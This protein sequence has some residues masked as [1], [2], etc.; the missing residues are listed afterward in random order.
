MD[1]SIN[2][3]ISQDKRQ[4]RLSRLLSPTAVI[5]RLRKVSGLGPLTNR[6]IVILVLLIY[7]LTGPVG[8][9]TDIVSASLAYALLVF[10]VLITA[11]VWIQ[12]AILHRTL[13]VA[14][15]PPAA[16]ASSQESVRVVF[17]IERASIIPFLALELALQFEHEGASPALLRVSGFS[18]KERR[19]HIDITFPHR[20][21]WDIHGIRCTV[22]DTF[23]FA[24]HSW[25][26][27]EQTAI[28]IAPPPA[29]D[30][31]LPVL[32]STQR[33]GEMMVDILNRQGDP[34]DIKQYHPADGIKKIV[35]KAFA[36][37]GELLSRHPE[38]SMTPEGFVVMFTIAGKEGDPACAHA[39]SYAESLT[40]LNLEIIASCEG[41][42][43]RPPARS[44]EEL[45]DLLIDSV[46]DALPESKD[47]LQSDVAALL[48][49][50]KSLTPG[51]TVSKLLLFT[52]AERISDPHHAQAVQAVA[53]WL[54]GQGTI[55][56][57]CITAPRTSHAQPVKGAL[58]ILSSFVTTPESID[59]ND[60]VAKSY[61]SFL[62]SCLQRN[63][64][65]YV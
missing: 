63:W 51:I 65:V 24:H 5:H 29:H 7:L 54:A 34:F 33:P 20:G 59:R 52:S 26:I 55:P 53:T 3:L 4:A 31:T 19:A 57:F 38:A 6:S 48:D 45:H 11:A 58:G 61:S 30:S 22:K 27:A 2:I 25:T 50:C 9:S 42:K 56:A 41:A 39:Q 44:V 64:E 21:S 49:Y 32:S 40:K 43:A 17:A 10:I 18:K 13:S 37:R 23:G 15:F 60:S 62:S 16:P 47:A 12:G 36:K 1:K 46:W 14:V 8:T 35:W 28:P